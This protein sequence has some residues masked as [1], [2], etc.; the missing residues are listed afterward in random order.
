MTR[1]F[2]PLICLVTLAMFF[3]FSVEAKG[4]AR[5][6]KDQHAQKV[7]KGPHHSP[8][9]KKRQQVTHVVSVQRKPASIGDASPRNPLT[10]PLSGELAA[11]KD[12]LGLVRKGKITE[13]SAIEKTISDPAAQRLAQWPHAAARGGAALGRAH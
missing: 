8:G 10:A 9:A 12:V 1:H 11:L 3:S 5:H 2:R 7:T 4:P 6:K 13:A